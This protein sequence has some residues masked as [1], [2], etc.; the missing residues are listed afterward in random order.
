MDKADL[1]RH[2]GGHLLPFLKPKA[3]SMAGLII[4]NREPDEAV[5]NAPEDDSAAIDSCAQ[6]LIN[7][8]HNKDTKAVS[9]ALK[10]A[11]DIL[12]SLPHEENNEVPEDEI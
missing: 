5:K 9:A 7:A 11:F 1:S 2:F 8:I 12:E 3:A 6:E 4:K 10:D